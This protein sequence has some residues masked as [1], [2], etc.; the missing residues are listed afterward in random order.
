MDLKTV[1]YIC[2]GT[3]CTL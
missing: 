1:F 2:Y 3:R